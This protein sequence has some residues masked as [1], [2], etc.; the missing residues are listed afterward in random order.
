MI[1]EILELA[2]YEL[3][4][5]VR[6]YDSIDIELGDRFSNEFYDTVERICLNPDAWEIQSQ[7]SRRAILKGFPYAILYSKKDDRILIHCVM[8]MH[9]NPDSWKKR[10]DDS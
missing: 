4:E 10:I 5:A 7:N 6:Y 2:Q 8:H 1:C 3:R 9:R